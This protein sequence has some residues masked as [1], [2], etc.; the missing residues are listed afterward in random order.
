MIAGCEE[1]ADDQAREQSLAVNLA[2]LTVIHDGEGED[3]QRHAEE[4]EEQRRGVRKGV[5]DEDEGG[6]PYEDDRK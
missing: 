3:G 1:E 5:F 6:S 4:I 2:E